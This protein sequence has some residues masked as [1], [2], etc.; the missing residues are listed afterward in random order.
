MP[1][2]T[3]P[4]SSATPRRTLV[5][6]AA[7]GRELIRLTAALAVLVG[8]ALFP[9]T[10]S[11]AGLGTLFSGDSCATRAEVSA[12]YHFQQ[13]FVGLAKCESLCRQAAASCK[14][15]MKA[16][17]SCQLA[18][19]SDFIAFDSAVECGGLEG[20]DRKDCKASASADLKLWRS[21]I[22]SERDNAGIPTCD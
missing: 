13:S 9:A 16:A 8:G 6:G 12:A 19:A 20:A 3:T 21:Q 18:L 14:Q 22:K 10:A 15:A 7:M 5:R 11:R 2:A 1:T 4:S 17:F